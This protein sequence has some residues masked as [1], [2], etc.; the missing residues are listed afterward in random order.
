MKRLIAIWLTCAA[1]AAGSFGVL[2]F[3]DRRL[4]VGLPFSLPIAF[5]SMAAA[6]PAVLSLFEWLRARRPVVVQLQP[7]PLSLIHI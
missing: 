4:G 7:S 3:E 2:M 6:V 1:A 5:F